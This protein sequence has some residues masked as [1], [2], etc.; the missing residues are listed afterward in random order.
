MPRFLEKLFKRSKKRVPPQNPPHGVSDIDTE[1]DRDSEGEYHSTDLRADKADGTDST[2][3]PGT[4]YEGSS[5]IANQDQSVD[6]QLPAPNP[7]TP[8]PGHDGGNASEY[9][10]L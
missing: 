7:S 4:N 3:A 9:R 2:I 8:I 10:R 1:S 5:R 6:Q